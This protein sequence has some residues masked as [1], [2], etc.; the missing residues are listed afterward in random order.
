MRTPIAVTLI[1][2][3]GL[4]MLAPA[5]SDYLYQRNIVEMMSRPGT[6]SVNLD[7]KMG[8]D[9]RLGYW[10]AGGAMVC[11][12]VAGPLLGACC[13]VGVGSSIADKNNPPFYR[14]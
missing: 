11:I 1:I 5:L 3:G 7:G 8:D 9:A 4:L 12:A 10:L 13:G 14:A 6:T 2:V